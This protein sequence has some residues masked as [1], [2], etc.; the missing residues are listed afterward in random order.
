[1]RRWF[2]FPDVVDEVAART[3][4]AGVVAMAVCVAAFGWGWMLVP[5]AAG[6]VLRVLWGPRVSPL[7][8]VVTRVVR[9]RLPFAPRPVPG[10]PKRF[11]QGVGVVFSVTAGLLWSVAGAPGAAR[12]VVAMLAGAAFLEAAFGLCLGCR[13]YALLQRAGVIRPEACP[14]CDDLSLRWRPGRSADAATS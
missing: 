8:L 9:P 6:F 4:A 3:V 1:V 2:S 7:A 14:A 12:V 10:S 13:A 5:L 11:A